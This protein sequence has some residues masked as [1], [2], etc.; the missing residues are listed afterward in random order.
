MTKS[1]VSYTPKRARANCT[2][3]SMAESTP[4]CLS[5]CATAA[6]SSIHAGVEGA[7][8]GSTWNLTLECVILV[9]GLLVRKALHVSLSY[10][11]SH[12]F[13]P[14]PVSLFLLFS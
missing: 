2:F 4:A 3:C 13:L 14:L 8:P 12:F 9:G 11:E 6:T 10:K 7:D 5:I 1:I